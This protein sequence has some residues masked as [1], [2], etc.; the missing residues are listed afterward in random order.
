MSVILGLIISKNYDLT[1]LESLK[2]KFDLGLYEICNKYVNNQLLD[3]EI[4]VQATKTGCDSDTG[5]GA[6]DIYNKDLSTIFKTIN[7]PLLVQ[8][9]V[10]EFE[11]RK[12]G[13]KDDV[14]RWIEIINLLKGKYKI[15]KVGLFWHNIH[16]GFAKDKIIFTNR[17]DCQIK[18][19]SI[20][21][22]MKIE[23]D[24]IVF[25]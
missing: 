14:L 12:Q 11:E 20:D 21:F 17:V 6:Y 7:D 8:S 13:Y 16:N 25:F 22:M 4:I 2:E 10:D 18:D 24:L 5:I 3:D 15:N 9:I 1:S 23:E 19:I